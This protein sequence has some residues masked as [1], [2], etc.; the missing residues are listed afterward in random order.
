M[1]STGKNGF[2]LI[3]L[4]AVIAVISIL[5]AIII[6]V[7]GSVRNS[8]RIAES[9]SNLRQLATGMQ[10]FSADNNGFYPI[11]YYAKPTDEELQAYRDSTGQPDFEPYGGGSAPY[12]NGLIWYAQIA[13]YIDLT[14]IP[15]NANSI[16]VSPFTE[17]VVDPSS[18]TVFCSYSVHGSIC[19]SVSYDD[20]LWMPVWNIKE[21]PADI[22]LIG[23]GTLSG[24]NVTLANFSNPSA[25]TDPTIP[26]SQDDIP[27][28]TTNESDVGALSYRAN[29]KALVGFLD[30]HVE[31]INQGDV[32]NRNVVIR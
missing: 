19:P 7:L 26:I 27:I 28:G 12:V 11:G 30:G 3:E 5:S 2:S 22:I 13:P 23:E 1:K 25:W 9:L 4:L 24:F 20:G 15:G 18:A 31:T 17:D 29:G 32:K 6:P 8:A 16:L 14:I 10:M 21:N